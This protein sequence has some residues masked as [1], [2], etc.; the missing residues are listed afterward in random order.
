VAVGRR[1]VVPREAKGL[2]A[3]RSDRPIPLAA[4]VA[5]PSVAESR[6][7]AADK[8]VPAVSSAVSGR[9]KVIYRVKSGDTLA[10]IARIFSTSVASIRQWNGI[11][12]TRIRTGDRLT[13]YTVRAN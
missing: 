11:T 1:L 9:V 13:I 7:L 2:M 4:A 5:P 10:S 3:A 12:G 6:A 8:V